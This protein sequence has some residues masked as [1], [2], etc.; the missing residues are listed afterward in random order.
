MTIAT[1]FLMSIVI[2]Y[3][4]VYSQVECPKNEGVCYS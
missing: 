3:Y 1:L 4:G 2:I